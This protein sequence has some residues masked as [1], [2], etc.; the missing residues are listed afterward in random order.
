MRQRSLRL[1]VR[2][3]VQ[4]VRWAVQG[5]RFGYK[6]LWLLWKD[7]PETGELHIVRLQRRRVQ[8][9]MQGR[10]REVQLELREAGLGQQQLRCLR[11][12]VPGGLRVHV[13]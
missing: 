6:Q 5:V 4:Q 8:L 13:W 3:W 2:N 12:H 11:R 1:H 9:H 7:L 10:V